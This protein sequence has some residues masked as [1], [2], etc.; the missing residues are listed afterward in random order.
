MDRHLVPVRPTLFAERSCPRCGS[1]APDAL[2]VVVPGVH[3]LGDYRCKACGY[4][5]LHDL[6]V[7]FA[8]DHDVAIGREDGTLHDSRNAEGWVWGPLLEG[9]RNP[10]AREV[11]VERRVLRPAK[12]VVILNTLDFLYGHVL[13]KLWN[14]QYY[15]D[16]HKDLGLVLILP[17]SFAWM[18]PEGT[19]EVWEVDLRLGEAH[20]W[21]PSIDRFV[22]ERLGEYEEVYFGKG[23]AH[24][25][26]STIDIRRFCGVEPFDLERFDTAPRH[27]TFV[28][29]DDRLWYRSR[30]MRFADR[31]FRRLGLHAIFGTV[32]IAD[33]ERLARATLRRIR[34]RYP[35]AQ[36]TF[37]G[38]GDAG[39]ERDGVNDLRT[40]R[41]SVEV[42]L[43][44]CRAYAASQ[45]VIGVHG[46]NMLL[47]TALA[48]G[49]IEVLPYDRYRNIV[50]DVAVR[51]RDVMQLFLYRFVD[52]HVS[53]GAV[54]RH[55]ISMFAD[56]R[57]FHRNNRINIY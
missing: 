53:P 43:A 52:E 12:R 36:A 30:M 42:E 31:V 54:A 46:S 14:A 24:P 57:V 41:M 26:K 13:L 33:Q 27:I 2:G 8:V 49:C 19:A 34:R 37:V 39:A 18:V 6:P 32:F 22:Q 29:R 21:Y 38:L 47:P 4:A 44:W 9:F 40:R 25:D 17:K 20:G 56:H 51:Q 3:V 50:Q 35:D 55:A 16:A 28:L 1:G 7:G 11:R 5:F 10:S 15:L 23:Y 45:F 48:G